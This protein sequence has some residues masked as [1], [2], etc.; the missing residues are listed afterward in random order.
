MVPYLELPAVYYHALI[1]IFASESENCPNILL[2]ALAAGRPIVCSDR[3]PMPEFGGD[4]VLYFDPASPG[5]LARQLM[6]VLDDA[7]LQSQLAAKALMRARLYDW[8][9]TAQLTW[10]ALAGLKSQRVNP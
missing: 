10:A 2:E 5:E 3:E 1:N 9:N 4:A 8:R 7:G 6:T